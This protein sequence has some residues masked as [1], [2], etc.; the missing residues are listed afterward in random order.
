[1]AH[2]GTPFLHR[3][4]PHRTYL[5]IPLSFRITA[6]V[7][8]DSDLETLQVCIPSQPQPCLLVQRSGKSP[9]PLVKVTI[10]LVSETVSFSRPRIS[11]L[12]SAALLPLML[13]SLN[14][15]LSL[16]ATKSIVRIQNMLLWV[17]T[18]PCP[19]RTLGL[20]F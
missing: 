20:R 2:G 9:F 19:Q 5:N 6:L 12:D 10:C 3:P 16:P 8:C 14:P 15:K 11:G 18:F 13:D 17:L 4:H 1:M 7:H